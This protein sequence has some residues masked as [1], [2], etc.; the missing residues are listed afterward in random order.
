MSPPEISALKTST[1][2]TYLTKRTNKMP[3]YS[4]C[5]SNGRSSTSGGAASLSEAI[6]KLQRDRAYYR[7]NWERRETPAPWD[8]ES[9]EV[10]CELCEGNGRIK[11]KNR[12]MAYKECKACAGKA[13][14][15]VPAVL[16]VST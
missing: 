9:I 1:R 2:D 8:R 3:N 10:A 14:L 13:W 15:P 5:I 6:T 11:I 7:G 16:S 4:Y 12:R